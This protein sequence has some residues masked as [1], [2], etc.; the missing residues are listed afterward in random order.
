MSNEIRN[1]LVVEDDEQ[2]AFLIQHALTSA[3]VGCD[4][5]HVET[6]HS[7]VECVRNQSVD[8]VLLDLS[9]RD[10]E[11]LSTVE[12]FLASCPDVPVIVCTGGADADEGEK[13]IARGAQD[14]VRKANID[15][16]VLRRIIRFSFERHKLRHENLQLLESAEAARAN[17]E[18]AERK[19]KK[20]LHQAHKANRLKSEF[21]AN[22]SHEI[23]TPLNGILGM[24]QLMQMSTLDA[25]H[26]SYVDTITSCGD[27]LLSI[28]NDVLDISKIEAGVLKTSSGPFD[29][30]V[31]AQTAID[32]VSGIAVQ[33]GI[34]VSYQN[35]VEQPAIFVGD[36]VRTKQV[37]INLVGNAVKFTD[38]GSVEI[39]VE[40]KDDSGLRF[41]VT[42]TGPGIAANHHEAVFERF[43]QV[44]GSNTREHG[45]TGLGLAIA[46]DLVELMGGEIGLTSK[47][48]EGSTF[49]FSL[50]LQPGAECV[51]EGVETLRALANDTERRGPVGNENDRR[52]RVLLVDDEPAN[53]MLVSETAKLLDD[54]ELVVAE[55]GAKAL[56]RLSEQTFELVLMDIN[57][58]LLTGE[59]SIRKLRSSAA[60]H[61]GIPIVALTANALTGQREQYLEAG[62]ADFLAKPVSIDALVALIQL[63][64]NS[65]ARYQAAA[66]Q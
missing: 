58:P 9:L 59:Q 45:G 1:I 11:S 15:P 13:A 43:R 42:D 41:S 56:E 22:M 29:A 37:L 66:N 50:P 61:A 17:A 48:G 51:N 47:I 57:T 7:A 32:A 40:R 46:K 10:S 33:K 55:N 39:H 44:D 16:T 21:L 30:D 3:I 8:V 28:I 35:T 34:A 65:S 53:Q 25:K 60:A 49:W 63:H 12:H 4:I 64:L 23:R 31:V 62:A 36:E 54:V 18:N 14:Y 24:A 26:Q 19:A 52:A 20:A 2:D 38:H 6:L 27:A 5:T